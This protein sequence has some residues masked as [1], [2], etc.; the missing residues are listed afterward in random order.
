M[1]KYIAH[2]QLQYWV[3]QNIFLHDYLLPDPVITNLFFFGNLKIFILYS[4]LPQKMM[5]EGIK[6][7]EI[8]KINRK[9]V[10]HLVMLQY[11]FSNFNIKQNK[12]NEQP[13]IFRP[14][15]GRCH[16]KHS[17]NH[18]LHICVGLRWP[19]DVLHSYPRWTILNV[20]TYYSLSRQTANRT[21]HPTFQ[22]LCYT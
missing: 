12:M 20:N 13:V 2:I 6:R 5:Q 19:E 15:K 21:N 22:L 1:K 7:V 8:N 10:Q 14:I 17:T 18:V 11:R 3:L 16:Y 4:D 9:Y